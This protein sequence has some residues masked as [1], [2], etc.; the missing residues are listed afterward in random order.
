MRE[1]AHELDQRAARAASLAGRYNFRGE[2]A[3]NIQHLSDQARYFHDQ[4]DNNRIGGS[5]LRSQLV[6]LLEDAQRAQE[7]MRRMNVGPDLA[8]EWNAIV[9]ILTRMRDL[10]GL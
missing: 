7:E 10:A 3:S 8:D 9:Q 1:L 5:E 6:H 4:I 2:Y